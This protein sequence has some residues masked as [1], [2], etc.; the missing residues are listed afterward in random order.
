MEYY[1]HILLLA[2]LIGIAVNVI[3]IVDRFRPSDQTKNNENMQKGERVKMKKIITIVAILSTIATIG[4]I[5]YATGESFKNEQL[6]REAWRSLNAKDFEGTIKIAEE[7]VTLFHEEALQ[8]QKSLE[9]K[10]VPVPPKG[11]VTKNEKERIFS[12]GLLN[13][14]ATCWFIL[15]KAHAGKSN[16][17]KAEKAFN[18]ALLFPYGR[19]FDPSNN[20]FWAPSDGAQVELKKLSGKSIYD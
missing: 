16:K 9:E 10:H 13:D 2:A 17:E 15:G 12:R 6:T 19:C 18:K 11:K 8:E 20:S 7:C 3:L 5:A 14:V 4:I 1:D